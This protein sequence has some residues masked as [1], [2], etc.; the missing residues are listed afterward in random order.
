M[1]FG[2]RWRKWIAACTKHV[3]F[4]VLVNGSSNGRFE[5]SKGLRQGDP[6]SPF[7]FI[8]VAEALNLMLKKACEVGWL[9]GFEV[10][11]GGTVVSHLQFAD[12]TIVFL[13]PRSA[14]LSHLRNVLLWFE[15]ISGLKVNFK[16]TSIIPV[17]DV[18]QVNS[19][20]ISFG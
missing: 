18:S 9:Q 8:L 6:L 1:G 15:I 4:S 7:I 16:K 12:D 11:E 13:Q 10:V 17:G 5:S 14:Q 19:L 20:A 3:Y 2:I